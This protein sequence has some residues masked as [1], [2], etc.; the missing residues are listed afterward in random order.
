MAPGEKVLDEEAKVL[1]LK[2]LQKLK[3]APA[4]ISELEEL[5]RDVFSLR[6]PKPSDYDHRRD[7]IRDFNV[8]AKEIY[9]KSNCPVVEEFGSFLMDIFNAGSDLDLS[10]NFSGTVVEF[11]RAKKIMV[12]KNFAKRLHTFQRKGRFTNLQRILT[13]RVPIVKVV[14]CGTGIECDIS[15]ENRDGIVKSRIVHMICSIDERFQKLSFLMK[16]WAKEHDINSSKDRTLNSLSI[17]LLVAFHLQT[18]D[19]PILPPFSAIVKDGTDPDTVMKNVENYMNYGKKNEESV[20]ELFFTLFVKLAAVETLWPSGLCCSTYEGAWIFKEWNSKVANMSVEDFSL[21]SENITRAV[22]EAEVRSIYN[23]IHQSLEHLVSFQESEIPKN[24]LRGLLF[25][26][27]DNL[28][29]KDKGT[30][31]ILDTNA[32]HY[33]TGVKKRKKIGKKTRKKI[34]TEANNQKKKKHDLKKMHLIEGW[35]AT[36]QS[37]VVFPHNYPTDQLASRWGPPKLYNTQNPIGFD[38]NGLSQPFAQ[39]PIQMD[40]IWSTQSWE[41]GIRQYH[42]GNLRS[43]PP[44]PMV[45]VGRSNPPFVPTE[46]PI[47]YERS[48]GHFIRPHH[49]PLSNPIGVDRSG[50]SNQIVQMHSAQPSHNNI[51]PPYLNPV[52]P[53]HYSQQNHYQKQSREPMSYPHGVAQSGDVHPTVPMLYSPTP[54]PQ[55]NHNQGQQPPY[56]PSSNPL[57]SVNPVFPILHSPTPQSQHNYN[58]GQQPPYAPLSNQP[59]IDWS[60]NVNPFLYSPTPQHQRNYNHGQQPPH[61]PFSNP[62]QYGGHAPQYRNDNRGHMQPFYHHRSG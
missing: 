11:P 41:G 22:G 36:Q 15:V 40:N 60:A 18:R 6:C 20:A 50:Y 61:I 59:G 58:Q 47:G 35:E 27:D 26:S 45:H 38:R 56:V 5:L 9:G 49:A 30:T 46:N 55:H 21:R 43:I 33:R 2:A 62:M 28:T 48:N 51:P 3:I 53:M 39:G 1:E 52:A 8:I 44:H 57:P 10:I 16:A 13:A 31:T 17:T 12:L 29:S 54:Q 23:C 32:G 34:E 7:L 14:D 25:G 37:S 19:P 4:C 42:V 24:E